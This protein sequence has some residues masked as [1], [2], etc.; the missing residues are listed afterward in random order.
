VAV[1]PVIA[2]MN[3]MPSRRQETSFEGGSVKH[4]RTWILVTIATLCS[5]SPAP[6]AQATSQIKVVQWNV[7]DGEQPGEIN[8]IVAQHPDIVFLQ[9][10]DDPAH[11]DDIVA[12]LETDQGRDWDVPRFISR[13]NNNSGLSWI[14]ILSRFTMSNVQHTS[15]NGQVAQLCGVTP[16]D[17]AAIGA[18]I[19]VDGKPLAIFST[20]NF[21]HSS[22]CPARE[23]NKIF[24]NWANATYPNITHLYGGDFNMNPGGSA[25]DVMTE[26]EPTSIDAWDVAVGN[27]TATSFD[28]NPTFTTPTKGNRLD[29]L[30]Y[31]NAATILGVE[32]AEITP[33]FAGLSDHRMM[34]AEFSVGSTGTQLTADLLPSDDVFIR[35]GSFADLNLNDPATYPYI[36]T[37]ASG[38]DEYRRRVLLKFDTTTTN[39]PAGATIVS[40][41][42]IVTL[43]YTN[44]QS[45]T[46]SA[47]DVTESG[48]VETDVTWNRRTPTSLWGTPGATLG[49]VRAT[50]TVGTTL[51]AQSVFNVTSWIQTVVNGQQPGGSRWTRLALVDEDASG[52]SESYKEFHTK[53]NNVAREL[54]PRLIVTYQ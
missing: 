29:Y 25:Y 24:K 52:T 34:I 32:S 20:R 23:Q 36:A 11:L 17:R 54:K 28:D 7:E 53:E 50:A 38:N 26:Q 30:F 46:V 41:S 9:E 19:V 35:G 33:E 3:T 43:K 1:I 31:K 44:S 37:R 2:V 5:P 42:L 8:A 10:V 49:S 18:N 21:W 27:G 12:A 14:A 39:I 4:F 15:L 13:H 48:W 47:F 6:F 40:A 45:R 22:E 16:D 51:G